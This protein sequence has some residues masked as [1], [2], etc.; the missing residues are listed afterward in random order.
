MTLTPSRQQCYLTLQQEDTS[1]TS[2]TNVNWSIA[3]ISQGHV[4]HRTALSRVNLV[5]PKHCL[6]A[7]HKPTSA[8]QVQQKFHG[9]LCDAVLAVVQQDIF[10]RHIVLGK[11]I[12]VSVEEVWDKETLLQT[13]TSDL[14]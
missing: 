1:A 13:N 3:S 4:Q 7:L 5:A 9:V 12:A 14:E 6:S 8:S 10:K 11:A 2:F